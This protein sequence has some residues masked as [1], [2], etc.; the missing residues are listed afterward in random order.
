M[1]DIIMHSE[2]AKIFLCGNKSDLAAEEEV[3]Q[4]DLDDFQ[5]Q[6][7]TVIS[8]MY[9][10]S[11]QTSEGVKEMF[12]EIA[13][14]L[15]TDAELRFDPTRIRPSPFPVEVEEKKKCCSGGT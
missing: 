11:C 3:T 1:L 13:R 14:I 12:Q 6:C 9:R 7:D 8:G 2:T 15:H 4:H 5:L 10:T